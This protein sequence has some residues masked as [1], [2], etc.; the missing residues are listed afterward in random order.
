[1]IKDWKSLNLKVDYSS[2]FN[3]YIHPLDLDMWYIATDDTII[4]GEIKNENYNPNSWESQKAYLNKLLHRI[5]GNVICL[6]IVHNKKYQNGDELIDVPS[7][8]V[9]EY[10]KNG[11]WYIPN[12]EIKVKEVFKKYEVS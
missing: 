7:C 8:I 12:K 9:K 6:F 3:S 4:I 1:M 10:Y 11:K 2:M 5:Q